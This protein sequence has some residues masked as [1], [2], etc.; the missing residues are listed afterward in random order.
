DLLANGTP[1][2][3]RGAASALKRLQDPDTLPPLLQAADDPDPALRGRAIDA[4]GSLGSPAVIDPLLGKL[5]DPGPDVRRAA[6][7][8]VA[9]LARGT[10]VKYLEPASG[11][12]GVSGPDREIT[13][14]PLVRPDVI[15]SA[16]RLVADP[17]PSV[18]RTAID[19]LRT[20][21]LRGI[22][23]EAIDVVVARLSDHDGDVS[24]LAARALLETPEAGDRVREALAG[25]PRGGLEEPYCSR[26]CYERGGQAI[27]RAMMETEVQRC[28]ICGGAVQP[29]APQSW[30]AEL[31]RPQANASFVCFAPGRDSTQ[32]GGAVFPQWYHRAEPMPGLVGVYF[33]IHTDVLGEHRCGDE[34][35]AV[36]SRSPMCVACGVVL[37]P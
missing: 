14:G 8:A 6:L 7:S 18:R 33:H 12:S 37:R 21:N 5:A 30:A 23:A 1:E 25:V 3:R 11:I 15:P 16:A 34:V 31:T 20:L 10:Q 29:R 9:T 36:V 22:P 2:Q 24:T 4:L 26:S 27:A 19:A 28:C 32:V 13:S 35:A 17:E